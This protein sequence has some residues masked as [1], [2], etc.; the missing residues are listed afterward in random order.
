LDTNIISAYWYSGSDLTGSARHVKT[1]EWWRDEHQHF[2]IWVSGATEEELAAGKFFRQTHCLRFLQRL[3]HLPIRKTTRQFAAVLVGGKVVPKEKPGV[4]L[5][6]AICAV[7]RI[8]YLLS[9]N[10][11]HL[12]N[13]V[14]QDKLETICRKHSY[15][16]PLLVSPESIPRAALGQ[17]IRRRTDEG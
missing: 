13:P 4:A 1:R 6:M 8:D 5:Q 10:Y 7:H 2:S 17:A 11:A 12:V 3:R 15:R 9:W 16:A 14:A